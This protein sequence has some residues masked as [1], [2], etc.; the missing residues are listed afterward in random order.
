MTLIGL[1]VFAIL[2]V[3]FFF[4]QKKRN[5]EK[6]DE[7]IYSVFDDETETK[8]KTGWESEAFKDYMDGW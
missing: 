1:V 2:G 7:D 3:L 5:Y 4:T 6:Q 8:K